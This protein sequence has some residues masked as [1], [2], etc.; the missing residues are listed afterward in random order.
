MDQQNAPQPAAAPVFDISQYE[1]SDTGIF[2]LKNASR[3][4]DLLGIDGKPDT[5]ELYSPGSPEGTKAIHRFSRKVTLRKM[6]IERE[7]RLADDDER[8]AE[9]DYIEKLVGFTK[10]F[11]A[12][13]P[14]KPADVY[15]NRRLPHITQ[16]VDE[17]IGKYGNFS[18][19]S[20]A[21]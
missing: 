15:S 2:N 7:G 9:E 20:S 12:N 14:V 18:K 10:S 21:S 11:S 5:V 3:D 19:G 1:L 4:A 8:R 13:F 16:Q 6:R 17:I